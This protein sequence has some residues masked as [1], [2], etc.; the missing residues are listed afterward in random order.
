MIKIKIFKQKENKL[1]SVKK[2]AENKKY[3]RIARW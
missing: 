3:H 1:S 2:Q